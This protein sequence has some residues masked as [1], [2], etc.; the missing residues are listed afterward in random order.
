VVEIIHVLQLV[1]CSWYRT[2]MFWFTQ[3]TSN[4]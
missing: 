2:K 4:T 3:N 1:V